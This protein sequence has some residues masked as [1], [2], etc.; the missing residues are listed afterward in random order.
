MEPWD[1]KEVSGPLP[2]W[3][4]WGQRRRKGHGCTS[5]K[6]QAYFSWPEQ[7]FIFCKCIF[8]VLLNIPVFKS[9]Q[10]VKTLFWKVPAQSSVLISYMR[11][12]N[13]ECIHLA[14][15]KPHSSGGKPGF[16]SPG[17]LAPLAPAQGLAPLQ[18]RTLHW[19]GTMSDFSMPAFD[20]VQINKVLY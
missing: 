4:E 15:P 16:V 14:D 20:T 8:G 13:W 5:Y 9:Y 2:G 11:K 17:V 3:C 1:S 12:M 10:Y 19:A 7:P 18:S 6:H